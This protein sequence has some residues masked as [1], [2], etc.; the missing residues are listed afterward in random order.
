MVWLSGFY[1]NSKDTDFSRKTEMAKEVAGKPLP[2]VAPLRLCSG[3]L[4]DDLAMRQ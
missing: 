4:A 3:R 1:V 2:T